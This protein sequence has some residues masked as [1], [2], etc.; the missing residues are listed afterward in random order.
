MLLDGIGVWLATRRLRKGEFICLQKNLGRSKRS[1][2]KL[3]A[4]VLGLPSSGGPYPHA[5]VYLGEA[6]LG[7]G[8]QTK[9]ISLQTKIPRQIS[10][11]PT[12]RVIP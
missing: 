5:G 6:G 12:L 1:R 8:V 9:R 11:L 7:R 3:S 4:L 2:R 10:G